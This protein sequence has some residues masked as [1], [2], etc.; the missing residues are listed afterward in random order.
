MFCVNK[1]ASVVWSETPMRFVM[2]GSLDNA[3]ATTWII[4]GYTLLWCHI[5]GIII[6]I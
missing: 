6:T 2:F 1:L 4:L 5:L 3:F